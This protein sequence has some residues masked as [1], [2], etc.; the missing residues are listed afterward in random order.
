MTRIILTKPGSSSFLKR[1]LWKS[2]KL[3]RSVNYIEFVVA[4]AVVGFFPY[5][6][7]KR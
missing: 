1:H 7:C 2:Q 4:A 5:I 6:C 3:E